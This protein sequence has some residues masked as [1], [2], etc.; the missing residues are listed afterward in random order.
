MVR[1]NF[2]NKK[3]SD[4]SVEEGT[5]CSG[6]IF[7][8]NFSTILTAAQCCKY[9][10]VVYVHFNDDLKNVESKLKIFKSKGRI[11][12]FWPLYFNTLPQ[13]LHEIKI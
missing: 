11:Q 6:S 9:K 7:H 5:I 2:L 4:E 13:G 1:L 3:Q 12:I 10:H 8:E